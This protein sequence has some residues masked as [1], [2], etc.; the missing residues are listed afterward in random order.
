MRTTARSKWAALALPALLCLLVIALAFGRGRAPAAPAASAV[1][2][3]AAPQEAAPASPVE[4]GR[5][6]VEFGGC[7]DCHSPKVMTANGPVVDTAKRLSGHPAGSRIPAVP[8]GALGPDGW[9]A[10][11]TPDLTAWAG[12]W[13]MSF[14]ANLTPDRSGIG[15]WTAEQFIGAMRTGKHMGAGRQILPPMPWYDVG[16]LTDDDL[17]AVFAYLRSLRPIAN[18]VPAPRPPAATR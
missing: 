7:N 9:G 18:E 13:G 11:T 17:R 15:N 6:L 8:A 3:T 10:L 12:P 1:A 5:Y 16:K 4:R 14:S 2:P